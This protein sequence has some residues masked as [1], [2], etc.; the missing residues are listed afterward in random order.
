MS[1]FLTFVFLLATSFSLQAQVASLT[2][3]I[4]YRNDGNLI[5]A[6]EEIDKASVNEKT[7]VMP[8]TWFY[9]GLIYKDIY[10]A[11]P[12]DVAALTKSTQAF[13]KVSELEK[14]A[15]EFSKKSQ[16]ALEQIWAIS[17][18]NG[19]SLYQ[20]ENYRASII[21]FERAQGIK[22][23]DTIAYVYAFYAANELKD[24]V[25]LEKYSSAL[26]QLNYASESVYYI[27]IESL[28]DKNL[29]DSAYSVSKKALIKYPS[30]IALKTQQT[31]LL[32][33]MNKTQE[34]IENLKV[35]SNKNP[36]DVQLLINIGSQ[37]TNLNDEQ[38]AVEYYQKALAIDSTNFNA[39]YNMAVF[40][41]RKAS[42]LSKKII[43]NDNAIKKTYKPIPTVATDPLRQDMQK[44]LAVASSY[45]NRIILSAKDDEAKK[46]AKNLQDNIK[47][48][49]DQFLR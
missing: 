10:Q 5:K 32:V 19:V 39:N 7:I 45:Y 17:I 46:N 29:L 27:D 12:T 42:D 24:Q 49:E 1:R 11:T 28:M 4:L 23:A 9:T 15:G 3:A 30:D 20:A 14:P 13:K 44:Q 21:D 40:S 38:H 43:A 34:A 8:K 2:N 25:L 22:P 36:K 47:S 48:F 16:E 26:V 41:L 37:Y 35:L 33:K 31:E 18:N 6:K